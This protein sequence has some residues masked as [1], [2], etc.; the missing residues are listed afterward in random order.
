MGDLM[1]CC[2]PC[3][4]WLGGCVL[5]SGFGLTIVGGSNASKCL[6]WDGWMGWTDG[7]TEDKM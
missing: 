6:A 4:V 5:W 3:L 2:V 1:K 7:W